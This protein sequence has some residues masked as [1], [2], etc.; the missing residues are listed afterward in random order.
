MDSVEKTTMRCDSCRHWTPARPNEGWCRRRAPRPGASADRIAH[1]PTT[2]GGQGCG[3]FELS[4]AS[5]AAIACGACR[6]WRSGAEGLDPVDR[7][8]KPLSWW[9]RAG[10]CLRHAPAPL[11]DPGPRAFWRAT[12]VG[13]GCGEG[14]AKG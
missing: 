11:A 14:A 2:H 8:D 10:H 6:F 5:T 4:A 1:W 7:A 12:H 3:D 9:S 13:D